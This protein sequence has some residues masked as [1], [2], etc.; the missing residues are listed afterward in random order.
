MRPTKMIMPL[1]VLFSAPGR[2]EV[3]RTLIHNREAMT[4]RSLARAAG[5][6]YQ[7]CANAVRALEEMGILQRSFYGKSAT[8][9]INKHHALVHDLL[10]PLF[11]KEGELSH[12]I[13]NELCRSLNPQCVQMEWGDL[14]CGTQDTLLFVLP[15]DRRRVERLAQDIR[16]GLAESQ[17]IAC[18]FRVLNYGDGFESPL[19]RNGVNRRIRR[20]NSRSGS[21]GPRR[22]PLPTPRSA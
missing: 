15:K 4:G 2:I 10:E 11:F 5:I 16:A 9:V 17:E 12:K 22:S 13:Q 14:F 1:S 19:G 18:E 20:E 8:V 6:G 7:A 3:L 21:A